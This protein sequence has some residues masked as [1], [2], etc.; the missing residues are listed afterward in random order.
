[1]KI[2]LLILIICLPILAQSPTGLR[3][4]YGP[5]MKESYL[6]RD[7]VLATVTYNKDGQICEMVIEPPPPL[8]PIKSSEDKLRS[9]VLDEV[10]NEVIPMKERGKL[11]M[12]SFLNM[13]CL[14]RNDCSGTGQDYEKVYIYKN[15][16]IDAHRY[17]TIQWKNAS[18]GK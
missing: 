10:I 2:V 13:T 9:E 11:I 15:G 1:M 7:N 14:P 3:Q 4:K 8:T 12:A 16:G 18:C 6:V 5:P 17:A